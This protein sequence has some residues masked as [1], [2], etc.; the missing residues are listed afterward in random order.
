MSVAPAERGLVPSARPN[1]A[2]RETQST[3]PRY[4]TRGLL[5]TTMT[6]HEVHWFPGRKTQSTGPRSAW[7]NTRS[8]GPRGARGSLVPAN[9]SRQRLRLMA[10]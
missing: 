2:R 10:S 5:V 3:G 9:S 7:R 4:R 6:G 8:T 1:G